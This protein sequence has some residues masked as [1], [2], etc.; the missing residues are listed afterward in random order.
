MYTERCK[1]TETLQPFLRLD[2]LVG[3][4][5]TTIREIKKKKGCVTSILLMT[6]E[7]KRNTHHMIYSIYDNSM[8]TTTIMLTTTKW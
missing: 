8:N 1:R 2:L 3:K 6:D 5:K 7:V 4:K